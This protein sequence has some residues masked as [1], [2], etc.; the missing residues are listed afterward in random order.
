MLTLA[1]GLFTVVLCG[2]GPADPHEARSLAWARAYVAWRDRA[3]LAA[4]KLPSMRL[5]VAAVQG[6]IRVAEFLLAHGA[7]IN[8][9]PDSSGETPLLHAAGHGQEAMA[10]WLL[11]HGATPPEYLS[12][13]YRISGR[14]KKVLMSPQVG[15]PMDLEIAVDSDDLDAVRAALARGANP[16]GKRSEGPLMLYALSGGKARIADALARA[17]DPN[18]LYEGVSENQAVC[19]AA[20]LGDVDRLEKMLQAKPELANCAANSGKPMSIGCYPP[21]YFAVLNGRAE[22]VRALAGA[23]AKR[24]NWHLELAPDANTAEALMDWPGPARVE[25]N[26]SLNLQQSTDRLAETGRIEPLAYVL[27][28]CIRREN[29]PVRLL[30]CAGANP[31]VEVAR[32]LMDKGIG[33]E[34]RN[35]QNQ[36]ALH[37]AAERGNTAV[38]EL[39]LQAGARADAVDETGWTPLA[40]ASGLDDPAI[41][42]MLI[43]HGARPDGR[44]LR[45]AAERCT[46]PDTPALLIAHGAAVNEVDDCGRSPLHL[47]IT[48]DHLSVVELLIESGAELDRP[49]KT[50]LTPLM[51]AMRSS[52]IDAAFDLLRGGADI[53]ARVPRD[54]PPLRGDRPDPLKNVA[55]GATALHLAAR[56]WPCMARMLTAFGAD[57]N[58]A[59][60]HGA[61]PLM[62][63]GRGYREHAVETVA[64]L[65]A[66]G[67]S[68]RPADANGMTA[69]HYGVQSREIAGLLLKAGADASVRNVNGAIPL[70]YAAGSGAYEDLIR[71]GSPVDVADRFGWTP[72]HVAA[73]TGNEYAVT[74]LL[75]AGADANAT[76]SL[77]SYWSDWQCDKYAAWSPQDKRFHPEDAASGLT[78]LHLAARTGSQRPVEALIRGKA[79][80]DVRD[81]RGRTPVILACQAQYAPAAKAL[82]LAGADVR[83]ADDSGATALHAAARSGRPETVRLLLDKGADAKA[84]AGDGSTALHRAAEWDGGGQRVQVIS[85]LLDA[86]ADVGAKDK[87]G[88]TPLVVAAER[89]ATEVLKLLLARGAKFTDGGGAELLAAVRGHNIANLEALLKAGTDPRARDADGRSLLHCVIMPWPQ[90]HECASALRLLLD[91]GADAK[92]ADKHG[93]TPL[94]VAATGPSQRE[95]VTA[96]LAA[97][98]E[99]DARDER[100]TTSLMLAAGRGQTTAVTLLLEKGADINATDKAGSSVID[101]VYSGFYGDMHKLLRERGAK[102]G[103][104]LRALPRPEAPRAPSSRGN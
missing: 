39:L 98:A 11:N 52:D 26:Y 32:Y 24:E 76:V 3:G 59:D 20:G 37:R 73:A 19:M 13:A 97:G 100:G 9:T 15:G 96:L 46:R 23:G 75:K 49:D 29:I 92:A 61:T 99:A 27:E 58:A 102:S 60:D 81:S 25:P 78:P 12:T 22:A 79:R 51:L 87:T 63:A 54:P 101:H 1:A 30:V 66:A 47:A 33:T 91:A 77:P 104:E 43:A 74:A 55:A 89:A 14:M 40:L 35:G 65:L 18:K 72:L 16:A 85:T 6:H 8:N 53:E 4:A 80:L 95:I 62:V 45:I 57:V 10:R 69:L 103:N 64:G 90:D 86:G 71:A 68:L 67:A 48:Y 44:C 7:D 93:R 34:A 36:T 2:C 88:R 41:A 82:I 94:H 21:T 17:C 31:R 70:H 42:R 84:A 28:T 5:H 38:A 56:S 83:A 50:G